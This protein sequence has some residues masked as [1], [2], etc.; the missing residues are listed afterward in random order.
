VIMTLTVV[1][2]AWLVASPLLAVVV[3]R[4][5]RGRVTPSAPD[6]VLDELAARRRAGKPCTTRRAAS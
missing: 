1:V 5:L 6:T 2:L 4:L 3:G